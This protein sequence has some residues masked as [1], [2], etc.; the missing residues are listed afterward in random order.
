MKNKFIQ[1]GILLS[2]FS[3]P[4]VALSA[5]EWDEKKVYNSGDVVQW[6]DLTYISSHWTQGTEPLNNKVNWDG[7]ITIN[8]EEIESW[9]QSTPYNGGTVVEYNVG[10]YIAKWWNN[11]SIP[12]DSAEWQRLDLDV[13][14]KPS[15]DPTPDD[16]NVIGKDSDGDGLRDDYA[17]TVEETYTNTQEV[18]LATQA[19]KEFGKLLEFSENN[20]E[21]TV[22]DAQ[23]MAIDGITIQYCID[24]YKQTNPDF[25]NPI[26]LYYDTI[27]RAIASNEA[28]TQLYKALQGN[29]P[30]IYHIDCNVFLEGV[31][32]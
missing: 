27:E 29:E 23:L 2:I 22:E 3:L 24:I 32:K 9:Q 26:D 20:I 28:S 19:G 10:Y 6:K 13:G 30:D 4:N 18:A 11:N 16:G 12:S 1:F 7:W 14:G 25:V 31:S 8:T 5:E 21:I 15:P 17:V